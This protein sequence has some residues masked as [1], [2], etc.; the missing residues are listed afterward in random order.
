VN[1]D[2]QIQVDEHGRISGWIQDGQHRIPECAIVVG[3]ISGNQI[4]FQKNYRLLWVLGETG[5]L[6]SVTE[7]GPHTVHYEGVLDSTGT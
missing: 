2:L 1:F 3:Q 7:D 5:E 6:V 4:G